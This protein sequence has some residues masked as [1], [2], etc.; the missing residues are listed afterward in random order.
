MGDPDKA[1]AYYSSAIESLRKMKHLDY[2]HLP[3][4][5]MTQWNMTWAYLGK[6]DMENSFASAYKVKDIASAYNLPTSY[7][8]APFSQ[9]LTLHVAFG[10]LKET[11]A[12]LDANPHLFSFF[13]SHDYEHAFYGLKADLFNKAGQ[14]DSADKY[15]RLSIAT[16]GK[17][18]HFWT[19][20]KHLKYG[21]FLLK[22]ERLP[23]AIAQLEIAKS[24]SVEFQ[25]LQ[26]LV[27][28]YK[29]LDSAY[30]SSGNIWKAYQHKRLY[31]R[32]NDSLQQLSK[33]KEVALL[34]V[35]NEQKKLDQAQLERQAQ[36]EYRNRIRTYSLLS[37]LGVL[38]LFSGILYRNNRKK[39]RTNTLLKQQK[40]K[41]EQALHELKVTQAQLV[42]KEKMASLGELTAGIAH[43][44]Q[45]PLNFVNNFSDVNTELV[46]ELKEALSSGNKVEAISIAGYIQDNE[47]K[48][49]LHGKRA[50]AIVKG[51][52]QHA[53]SFTGRKQLTVVNALAEEY[54]RLAYHGIKAQDKDFTCTLITTYDQ[55]L[56]KV[57]VVP[58][59][60]G[61]VLLNLFNNAFYA[62]Q[63]KQKQRQVQVG[64]DEAVYKPIV[65]VSTS[66][67]ED[68]VEI[69]MRDNGTGMPKSVESKV[70]H[71]FFTTKPSGQGTGLGLSIFYDI[72]TK[73]HGGE[74]RV[75]SEEGEWAEFTISIPYTPT[76]KELLTASTAP[77]PL[78]DT[79]PQP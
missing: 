15:Y 38:L 35:Q 14:V 40:E 45:N 20:G 42:Q 65:N 70:F 31:H 68:R 22:E 43:E 32:L 56:E 63:Q 49:N 29:A 37:G 73:G 24:K 21:H 36:R 74:M 41:T 13:L 61:R 23:E 76:S 4:L 66:Q 26:D 17:S 51:M 11:Q 77:L 30:F 48:I 8:N 71:P 25:N 27:T 1:L 60:L 19:P 69:R 39:K 33:D 28:S 50:D 5:Y 53:R 67:Q 75:A 58:Q 79:Y 2:R 54:L 34:E 3:W 10:K 46:V 64:F 78:E 52:L 18:V 6:G 55:N 47:Q 72:I 57:E 7:Q 59:E 9:L 62:V 12:L 16:V 44:I